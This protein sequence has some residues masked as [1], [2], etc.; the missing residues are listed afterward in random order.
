MGFVIALVTG[1]LLTA[2]ISSAA[3]LISIGIG[4]VA[5]GA[6]AVGGATQMIGFAVPRFCH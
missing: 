4:G 2:P 5:G 6:A 3:I 1:A